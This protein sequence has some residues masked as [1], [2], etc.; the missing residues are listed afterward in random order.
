MKVFIP[1]IIFIMGVLPV[2]NI[3]SI[4]MPL[5]VVFLISVAIILKIFKYKKHKEADKNKSNLIWNCIAL[6]VCALL[7]LYQYI[8]NMQAYKKINY[9]C[10]QV[11]S[12]K[13]IDDLKKSLTNIIKS[14]FT[15]MSNQNY[16]IHSYTI[17]IPY[18]FGQFATCEIKT[19]ENGN[20]LS[21][22]LQFRSID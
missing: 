12:H 2:L 22:K 16:T 9:I 4:Y 7:C 21:K 10:N 17:Y 8:A 5:I 3:A 20:I 6:F 15:E 14:E 1:L 11:D 18:R 13:N 19:D